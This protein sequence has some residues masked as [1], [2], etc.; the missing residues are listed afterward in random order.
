MTLVVERVPLSILALAAKQL[1]E[2]CLAGKPQE[3]CGAIYYG[4]IVV[5]YP[6]ILKNDQFSNDHHFAA[7]IDLQMNG[8]DLRAVWHSH[9]SGPTEPSETDKDFM[10]VMAERGYTFNHI[11]VTPNEVVEYE[12]V[13]V[14]AHS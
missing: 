10:R 2:M 14:D 3:V 4:D 8:K 5:Q 1:R 6:N 9:P 7:A 13:L 11:I 12:A